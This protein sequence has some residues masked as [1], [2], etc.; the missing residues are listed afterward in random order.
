MSPYA[1]RPPYAFWRRAFAPSAL[2]DFDP[3]TDVPFKIGKLDKVATAG[4]CFAQ[5]IARTLKAD[6]YNYFV[7]ERGPMTAGAVN[8]NY[9]VFP[10]RFANVYTV[11]QMLQLFDRSMGL[12]DPREI[13]TNGTGFVDPFRPRIQESGFRTKE[14]LKADQHAHLSCV[15]EMFRSCDVFVF[16]LGLTEGWVSKVDGSVYPLAPGVSG[17]IFREDRHAFENFSVRSMVN[18]LAAF[19]SKFR[20]LNPNV[21]I[22]LTVSPVALRATYEKRHVLLSTTYSKAA[23]RVVAEEIANNTSGVFYFPSYE[24]IM[25]PQSQ[26]RYLA[27]GFRDVTEKGVEAVMAVFRRHLLSDEDR[28]AGIKS[29][30]VKGEKNLT[31]DLAEIKRVAAVVCDEEAIDK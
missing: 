12:F 15:R 16:T 14:N 26:G 2:N 10:A 27:E 18:D 21:R 6:G 1:G 3:V 22:I 5:H 28:A 13:W 31:D 24:I 11:R 17:G 30:K 19:I 23:L 20:A 9:G 25:G 4:S 29:E 8:E 7:T